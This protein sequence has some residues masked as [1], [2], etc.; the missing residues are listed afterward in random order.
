M[1]PSSPGFIFSILLLHSQTHLTSLFL[2]DVDF[3]SSRSNYVPHSNKKLFFMISQ[4]TYS[5]NFTST[6]S[7]TPPS[8]A[9]ILLLV[10]TARTPAQFRLGLLFVK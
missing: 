3:L 4:I 9:S 8:F 1:C 5:S 6:D 7:F 10:P 2:A